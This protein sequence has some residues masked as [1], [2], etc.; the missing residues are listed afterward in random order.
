M[1]KK[2]RRVVF[3]AVAAISATPLLRASGHGPVFGLATPPNPQGGFSLDTSF[4]GRYGDGGGAMFRATLGYGLT[5][6]LKLSV[7]APVVF[8]AEPFTAARGAAFHPY[9]WRF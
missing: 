4:M 6:N 7:S 8:A 5:E 3:V 9:G 2:S 1:K